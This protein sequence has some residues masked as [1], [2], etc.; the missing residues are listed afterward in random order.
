MNKVYIYKITVD[1]GGAPCVSGD[2]LSLAI[3]KPAIRSTAKCGN[4]IL[5]FSANSLYKDNCLIY[6]ARVTKNLGGRK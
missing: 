4:I 2:I 6:V 5:G 1:N 3:C